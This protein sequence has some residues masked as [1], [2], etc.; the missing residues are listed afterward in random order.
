MVTTAQLH[1]FLA[2]AKNSSEKSITNTPSRDNKNDI[3]V[4]R[5]LGKEKISKNCSTK[6]KL[7]CPGSQKLE[8]TDDSELKMLIRMM[9]AGKIS[10]TIGLQ[11]SIGF[12]H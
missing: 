6:Q 3:T 10:S 2:D 12:F 4:S 7:V 11:H 5:P 9:G 8:K 1:M